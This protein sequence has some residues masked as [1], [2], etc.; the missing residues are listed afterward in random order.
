M[1]YLPQKKGTKQQ[2]LNP[3]LTKKIKNAL[4]KSIFELKED[5]QRDL[6]EKEK[7]LEKSVS[8]AKEQEKV[9]ND[10]EE[11][12]KR[13]R[14]IDEQR[15]ALEDTHGPLDEKEIQKLKQEKKRP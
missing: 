11:I 9:K 2:Y 12:R 15:A 3:Q 13:M 5:I 8:M 7:E 14:V 4:G 6:A 10:I 1:T